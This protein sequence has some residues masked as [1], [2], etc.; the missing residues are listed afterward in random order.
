MIRAVTEN[1]AERI[2]SIYNYYVENTTITFEEEIISVDDMK[3]RISDISLEYPWLVYEHEDE[4]VAYAYA[5]LWKSR[6][7]Y[8]YSLEVTIYGANDMP[9]RLG[10]GTKLYKKLFQE[11]DSRMVRNLIA[12]IALPNKASVGLHEKLGFEKAGHF[13]EVG[14][15]FDQWIDVGYWQKTL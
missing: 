1:D 12:V 10:I 6:C 9:Q 13:K 4:I 15:K 8:R 11:L 7:A 3:D 2:S 5:N 14:Y